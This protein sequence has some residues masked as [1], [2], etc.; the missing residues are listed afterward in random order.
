VRPAGK[1]RCEAK[2]W[3]DLL[4]VRSFSIQKERFFARLRMTQERIVI[5]N[6]VKDLSEYSLYTAGIS[7]G[8]PFFFISCS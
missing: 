5:L 7:H 6:E 3:P 4:I 8:A 1:K 2:P